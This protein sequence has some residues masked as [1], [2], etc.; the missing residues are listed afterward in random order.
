MLSPEL[1]ADMRRRDFIT[2]LGGAAVAW[3]LT[4]R[5]QQ[6]AGKIRRIGVLMGFPEG[7]QH[8]QAFVAALRQGLQSLG[9]IEGSNVRIDYRWAG[10]DPEKA[11]TF[12]RELIA[13]TP[14]VIVPSTNQVTEIVRQETKSIPI[15][16]AYLGDPVGSGLVLSIQRPG[17]NVTGFPVFVESMGSKWLEL[18]REVA[19]RAKRAGFIFHPDA[20]PNVGLFRAAEAAA[21]SLKLNVIPIPVHNAAEIE[22]GITAFSAEADGGLIVAVHAVTVSS[23]AL[24]IDLAA[25]HRLPAVYGDRNF[26]ESGGLL[27]YG[28]NGAD[29]FRRAAS[30]VDLVLKG[31]KPADLPV[32]LP[33]KF[34]LIVNL[35]TAKA[36]GLDVPNTL[37]STADVVIE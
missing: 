26:T 9:W 14:D 23:R 5:A 31:A 28:S 27:S 29:L 16:F 37:L 17:G 3:P 30:Y 24:I 36:L 1:G 19:P 18:F 22:R 21:P 2:L 25:R 34:E 12:A 13:M 33:T 10:G 11:R 32:Q 35:K 6:Q 8:G 15:V 20:V 7:D 4:A